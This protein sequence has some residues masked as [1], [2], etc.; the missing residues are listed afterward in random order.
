MRCPPPLLPR[1]PLRFR[2]PCRYRN[3]SC[4]SYRSSPCLRYRPYLRHHHIEPM[5]S[6]TP[7]D[8]AKKF[9]PPLPT[10]LKALFS[11]LKWIRSRGACPFQEG[12]CGIAQG[13]LSRGGKNLV[14]SKSKKCHDL[15]CLDSASLVQLCDCLRLTRIWRVAGWRGLP[16]SRNFSCPRAT[17]GRES[18]RPSGTP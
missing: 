16:S 1:L 18:G 5:P 7:R 14:V 4:P 11:P 10:I 9:L 6:P 2:W 8:K 12:V 3:R 15:A 13:E 17:G